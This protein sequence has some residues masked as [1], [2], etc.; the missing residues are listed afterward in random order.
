MDFRADLDPLLLAVTY[1]GAVDSMLG[2]LDAHPH[3]DADQHAAT[4]ADILLG[5]IAL[6]ARRRGQKTG[7]LSPQ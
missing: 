2:F 3:A 1:Q 4:V 5:G 7:P 6:P